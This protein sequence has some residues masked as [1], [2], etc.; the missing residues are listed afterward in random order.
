MYAWQEKGARVYLC[1]IQ[2]LVY[3][4]WDAEWKH[5][6]NLKVRWFTFL[7][8][9]ISR[10]LWKCYNNLKPYPYRGAQRKHFPKPIQNH[11]NQTKTL[12]T[13]ES[14][15]KI[16]QIVNGVSHLKSENLFPTTPP[17]IKMEMIYNYFLFST[18]ALRP[19]HQTSYLYRSI[20]NN[21]HTYTATHPG[22]LT[23]RQYVSS[24]EHPSQRRSCNLLQTI[25]HSFLKVINIQWLWLE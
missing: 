24:R 16:T 9:I 17:W 13:K 10:S 4:F 5:G 14:P 18:T 20:L 25:L 3:L 11:W 1:S 7:C 12:K 6:F 8:S 22:E 2:D 21:Q 15:Q 19:P 23:H